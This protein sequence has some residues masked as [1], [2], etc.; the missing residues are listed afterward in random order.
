M[1]YEEGEKFA[2]ENNLMFLETSARTAF[3][4]QET[5]DLSAQSIISMI[6]YKD[7]KEKVNIILFFR[8]MMFRL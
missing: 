5:F 2:Q 3:N 1:T 7:P 6:N 4:I 8:M